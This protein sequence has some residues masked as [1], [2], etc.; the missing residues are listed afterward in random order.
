MSQSAIDQATRLDEIGFAE[1]TSQLIGE[2]FDALI[3][4]NIR[5]QEV[6]LS[7][8]KEVSK[9]LSDYINQ[10]KDDISGEEL[11]QFVNSLPSPTTPGKA[12]FEVGYKL[13]SDD[14]TILNN[15]V[16]IDNPNVTQPTFAANDELKK[17]SG[18][19][20]KWDLL[21]DA[22]SKRIAANKY[23]MLK[24]ILRQGML[25]LVVENGYLETR[26]TF[27]TW[28][29]HRNTETTR[30]YNREKTTS[31]GVS[32]LV[33][34]IVNGPSIGLKRKLSVK[35]ATTSNTDTSGT[36]I[37]VFGGVKLQ[38]KTDYLPLNIEI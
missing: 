1:F 21:L 31:I 18:G 34:T 30:D 7:M 13:T 32:G 17:L 16:K 14:A 10:T 9:S 12:R 24:I 2:T 36:N 15:A 33:S 11:L 29:Y 22:V 19:T 5:Q 26:L 25:R 23:D 20:G 4:A 3:S 6:Y 28:E 8:V 27:N 37:S 35:T 38:F